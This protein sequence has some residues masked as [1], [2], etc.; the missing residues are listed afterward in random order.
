MPWLTPSEE[1]DTVYRLL[2]IPVGFITHVNGALCSLEYVW[3][4][5]QYGTLTPEECA[6]AMQNMVTR[7]FEENEMIGVMLPYA[8]STIPDNL[9]DC[10]GSQYARVDYPALYAVLNASYIVDAD[11][12][13]VP[14]MVDRVP[15]GA[16]GTG[17]IGDLAGSETVTLDTT[18]IPAHT[19]TIQNA[20]GDDVVNGYLG[21]I[22][23]L[24]ITQTE[25][26][27]SSTGEGE[28]HENRQPTHYTGWGIVW[29]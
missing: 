1:G 18:E 22:G 16:G 15:A 19:H 10:D 8:T 21:A 25:E 12:F 13:T 11:H 27:T 5:E 26:T 2:R 23:A 14:N 7:Y 6:E 9:L 20:Y 3:N 4:W 29:R 17:A 24:V 28:A